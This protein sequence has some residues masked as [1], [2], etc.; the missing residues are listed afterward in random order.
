MPSIPALRIGAALL[1][2]TAVLGALG[3][4]S[5]AAFPTST[6][7]DHF[8]DATAITAGRGS[9]AV[10]VGSDNTGDGLRA[11]YVGHAGKLE[12]AKGV[13]RLPGWAQ[14]HVGIDAHQKTV[15]LYPRCT[16]EDRPNTCR[17]YQYEV[18]GQE[19]RAVPQLAGRRGVL[20]GAMDH[21]NL[22]YT[23]YDAAQPK[24]RTGQ[25]RLFFL[26][27]GAK[28]AKQISARGAVGLAIQGGR[29]AQI[30]N[31]EPDYGVCGRPRLETVP[32]RGGAATKIAETGCGLDGQSFA[33]PAFQ[34][35]TLI[36]LYTSTPKDELRRYDLTTRT[37][38]RA[39]IG[40]DP[41]A[42]AATSATGGYLLDDDQSG[43]PAEEN[44]EAVIYRESTITWQAA[45]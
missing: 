14:P 6:P 19:E 23:T 42:Y 10:A 27:K 20:E 18:L 24:W 36:W 38:E 34:G 31:V 15:V 17:L 13:G 39:P 33:S 7:L 22:A 43:D 29:V 32:T 30:R 35:N 4:S 3:A 21:G 45:R 37:T 2:A 9:V 44:P 8:A 11:L 40:G 41:L 26:G 1:G 25:R 16:E 12:A 5:A 28:V